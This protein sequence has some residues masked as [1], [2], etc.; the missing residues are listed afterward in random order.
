MQWKLPHLRRRQHLQMLIMLHKQLFVVSKSLCSLQPN[1]Q[2]LL[3]RCQ[4]KQLYQLLG[5][6]FFEWNSLRQGMPQE[7]FLMLKL[8]LLHQVQLWLHNFHLQHFSVMRTMRDQL[9]ILR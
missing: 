4:S 1:L 8:N 9:Q 2:N 6:I 7:L 3:Q 5:W